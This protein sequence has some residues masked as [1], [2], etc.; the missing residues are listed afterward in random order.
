MS[1]GVI[2][3]HKELGIHTRI[4]RRAEGRGPMIPFVFQKVDFLCSP[5]NGF[6]ESGED[7]N[8][9]VILRRSDYYVEKMVVVEN[10]RVDNI[11]RYL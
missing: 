4:L 9:P 8:F 11:K 7:K 3:I 2:F 10:E 5:E 1:R 6:E